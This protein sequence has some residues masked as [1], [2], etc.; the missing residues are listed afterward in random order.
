ML[1]LQILS[2]EGLLKCGLI[3][4]WGGGAESLSKSITTFSH[5]GVDDS[6]GNDTTAYTVDYIRFKIGLMFCSDT[7]AF[8]L[9][10]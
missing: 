6:G 3:S 2:F 8:I 9:N 10:K 1:L 4:E 5:T 7:K